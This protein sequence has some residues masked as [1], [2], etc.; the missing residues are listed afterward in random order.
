V[1]LAST[2]RPARRGRD[3]GYLTG[4][5]ARASVAGL[6]WSLANVFVSVVLTTAV[7]LVTSRI[8]TPGEFGAVAMAVAIV[9]VIGTLVPVAFGEA[10]VQRVELEE[11]HTDTVFWLTAA[12]AL[13][14][15]GALA[16]LAPRIAV[17]TSTPLLTWILPILS[18]RLIFDAGLTVPGALITRRMEFRYIAIRTTLANG[19]GA[20]LC[21]WMVTHGY[22][23]MALVLSQVV[24]SVAA[25]AISLAA[26]GWR[27][28]FRL[29]LAALA[30]LRRFGL[31]SMGGRILNEAR[32]DQLLLGLVLGPAVLGLYFFARRLFMMLR[33][34]TAGVFAPVTNVLLASLQSDEARRREF[35]LAACFAS[36]SL[37]FPVFAGLIAVAPGA[38]P[39]VFGEQWSEAVFATQ[40]FA[41][42]G[43][44][45][46]LGV[47]QA[48]LIRYLGEPGWWFWY[49]GAMQLSTLPLIL[50]LAPF[51]LDAIMAA[52]VVRTLALWPISVAKAQR[53][54]GI[55]LGPYLRTLHAPAISAL[56]M[57]GLVAA[58]PE[59]LPEM[60]G[61]ARL[62]VQTGGGAAIYALLMLI[63]ARSDVRR[64]AAL[65]RAEKEAAA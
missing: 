7:F 22:A 50:L 37:A 10:L 2:L 44:L 43:L 36:A 55:G 33:D 39:V 30:D 58:L 1:G 57:A 23:L 12:M 41:V 42:V 61:A 26:A 48:G 17:W 46:G 32:L 59:L 11:R 20:A 16:L 38:V 24:T 28:G 19:I 62:C 47:M 9:S 3:F 4:D 54:L 63:L 6:L 21:L 31:F 18:V 53:M 49:Q 45:T 51:G 15:A 60:G 52:V 65:W 25:F 56:L 13:A 40:C 14:G 5:R 34:L 27:P 29:S 64:L 35:Y 8:L